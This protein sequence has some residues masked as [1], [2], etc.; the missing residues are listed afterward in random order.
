MT[1]DPLFLL[2]PFIRW[3]CSPPSSAA[4]KTLFRAEKL[5]SGLGEGGRWEEALFYF[6]RRMRVCAF[7]LSFHLSPSSPRPT[8]TRTV[9][10][11][12][13]LLRVLRICRGRMLACVGVDTLTHYT[14][15]VLLPILHRFLS[16][17]LY[18]QSAPPLRGDCGVRREAISARRT[19]TVFCLP[20]RI[21][22]LSDTLL[23]LTATDSHRHT[24]LGV[25]RA[26]QAARQFTSPSSCG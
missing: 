13:T 3:S 15:P 26:H 2:F 22:H 11:C 10:H 20:L 5:M 17:C 9:L 14:A 18:V 21:A 23:S 12:L 25:V 24:T 6:C 4:L 16:V 7:T 19:A 8:R 1:F